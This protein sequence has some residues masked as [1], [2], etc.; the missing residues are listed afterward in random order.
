MR[1]AEEWPRMVRAGLEAGM[2]EGLARG[3]E[4]LARVLEGGMGGH[5][6]EGM[7]RGEGVGGHYLSPL[8]I[9]ISPRA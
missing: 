1:T 7:A 2:L 4:G 3:L 8:R 5:R 6:P 9:M